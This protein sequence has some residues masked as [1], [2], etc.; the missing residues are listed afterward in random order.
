MKMF[1]KV[2]AVF[3]FIFAPILFTETA[4]AACP[5]GQY[6]ETRLNDCIS[7]SSSVTGSKAS[8][9]SE[10]KNADLAAAID[11]VKDSTGSQAAQVAM[12]VNQTV[13]VLVGVAIALA[14]LMTVF[15]ALLYTM[16]EGDQKK[17]QQAKMILLG[18]G[19]GAAIAVSSYVI[20]GIINATVL[21]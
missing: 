12:Y 8:G 4:N 16:S 13:T 7:L 6:Y 17:V 1:M 14:A 19:V 3:I 11:G 18:A 15:G 21:G 9:Y 20:M 10:L 2:I 5:M